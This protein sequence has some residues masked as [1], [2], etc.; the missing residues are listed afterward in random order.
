MNPLA[1]LREAFTH[2]FM[3]RATVAAVA[4][5]LVCSV[6]SIF[7]VLRRLAFAGAGISHIAFGGV[8]LAVVL[9]WPPGVGAAVFGMGAASLLSRR[10]SRRMLSEDTVIG[11]LFAAAM[12]FGVV[13]LQ[14]GGARNVDL[15]TYL[16]GNILTISQGEMISILV[17][18]A[19]VLLLLTLLFPAFIFTSFDEEAAQLSGLPVQR[20]N[21]LLLVLLALTI[22][23]SIRAVGLL[24]VAAMLVIPGAVAQTRCRGMGSF[25]LVSIIVGVGSTLGG[26]A[27]SYLIDKPSGAVIVLL[28]S[29][30]LGFNLLVRRNEE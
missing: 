11:V 5:A 23:L 10:A 17:L 25:I 26:L 20:L 28:A 29:A 12:A 19:L 6:M 2:A 3:I 13:L 1:D 21:L 22:V 4:V 7:V 18:S 27:L 24:L 14:F 16:F 9:G 30:V 8:A 15:M